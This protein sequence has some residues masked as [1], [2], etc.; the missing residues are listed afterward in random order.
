[1]LKENME[2]ACF[3]VRKNLFQSQAKVFTI[4]NIKTLVLKE[5]LKNLEIF[6]T[7]GKMICY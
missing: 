2:E 4:V 7:N 1:M 5:K 6:K 3:L